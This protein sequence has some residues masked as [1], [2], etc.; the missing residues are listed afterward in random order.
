MFGAL[1]ETTAKNHLA[2]VLMS[3]EYFKKFKGWA[4]AVVDDVQL[5]N[6][7]DEGWDAN[8]VTYAIATA[9]SVPWIQTGQVT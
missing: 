4:C 2:G 9:E 8:G 1:R 5:A 6:F 3:I 7:N